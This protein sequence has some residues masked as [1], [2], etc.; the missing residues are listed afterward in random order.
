MSSTDSSSLF[1]PAHLLTPIPSQADLA[2][3]QV[4][5]TLAELESWFCERASR[6][7]VPFRDFDLQPPP[8]EPKKSDTSAN[9]TNLAIL[10]A[11][12]L[13]RDFVS[14]ERRDGEWRLWYRRYEY[15]QTP[16]PP[17]LL[18]DAPLAIRKAFLLR[19]HDF[20]E[21]YLT[22]TA[23]ALADPQAAVEA[24]QA[25]LTALRNIRSR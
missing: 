22:S 10:A 11:I 13:P 9:L 6:L 4:S 12:V 24:G 15:L 20:S 16:R 14:L 1:F 2:A 5:D 7:G 25:T 21:K 23:A 18:R 17:V 19:S 8:A 3:Q